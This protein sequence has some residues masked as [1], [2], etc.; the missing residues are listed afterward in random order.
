[1]VKKVIVEAIIN[2]DPIELLCEPRQSL[3]E[4]L[5]DELDMTGS[6]EGCLT[7]DCGAC[8]VIIDGR[9]VCTLGA[10][11]RLR[12]RFVTEQGTLAQ[13]P[14]TTFYRRLREKFG[15]LATPM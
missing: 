7:G 14:G 15:R 1:M 3:L 4:V 8:T 6:K 13:I 5:R 2:G 12:T 9:P 11:E 10:G